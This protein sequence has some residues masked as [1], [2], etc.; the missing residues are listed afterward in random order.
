[1]Q[2]LF[3]PSAGGSLMNGDESRQPM[4]LIGGLGSGEGDF[5]A[6]PSSGH[7]RQY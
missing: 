7:N 3:Q 6:A 5:S 4:I 1:M 2:F